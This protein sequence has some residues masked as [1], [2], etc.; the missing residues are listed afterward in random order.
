MHIINTLAPVFLLIALGAVL[1]KTNF[2]STDFVDGLSR[3]AYW[4]GLPCILFYKVATAT[5]D[6][7]TA[8]RTYLVFLS[9]MLAALFVSYLVA[10]LMSIPFKTIGTFVQGSFQ[11]NLNFI[12]FAVILYS[13]ANS[14]LPNAAYLEGLAA[15]VLVLAVLSN[16][17]AAVIV[18]LISQHNFGFRSVIPI[19]KGLFTNPLIVA[20]LLGLIY[21]FFFSTLPTPIYVTFDA[22]GQVALPAALLAIGATLIE[23]KITAN[24][25]RAFAATLIKIMVAPLVGIAVASM[26][27][28]GSDEKIIP[29]ILLASPTAV[30]SYILSGRLGGKPELSTAIIVVSTLFSMASLAA[31]LAFF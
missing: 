21:S 16:N 7:S 2:F 4:V 3:L 31:I 9:G 26:L 23:S 20:S 8:G 18:L 17:A 13:L 5:Y 10:W 14:N 30:A 11:G 12:G 25:S 29:L 22:I 27:N 15:I 24:F 19:I 6:F 28:I 1:K